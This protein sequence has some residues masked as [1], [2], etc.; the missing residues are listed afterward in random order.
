MGFHLF[1]LCHKFGRRP[2]FDDPGVLLNG[3]I[4][5][6]SKSTPVLVEVRE[7]L[8]GRGSLTVAAGLA[9]LRTHLPF[10]VDYVVEHR[11]LDPLAHVLCRSYGKA[12]TD[13]AL[14]VASI[15]DDIQ[16]LL[17]AACALFR[18]SKQVYNTLFEIPR[19][20]GGE[21]EGGDTEEEEPE[22][23]EEEDNDHDD[24]DDNDDDDDDDD[25][26]DGGSD[27]DGSRRRRLLP[28]SDAATAQ[29]QARNDDAERRRLGEAV[30]AAVKMDTV[31]RDDEGDEVK[32]TKKQQEEQQK[33]KKKEKKEK[34]KEKKVKKEKNGKKK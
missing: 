24:H 25:G 26:D 13:S 23:V 34:K 30:A 15:I 7:L 5:E 18:E 14:A 27:G 16:L 33:H 12:N 19:P 10:A 6:D 22:E 8:T 9:S 20:D 32:D 2:S 21:A 1:I 11:A 3:L 17:I 28:L 4:H 31:M 29:E